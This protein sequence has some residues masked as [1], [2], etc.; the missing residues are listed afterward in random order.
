MPLSVRK[1]LREPLFHFLILGTAIFIVFQLVSKSVTS[2]PGKIFISQA[3]LAS[4]REGYA[5]TWHRLPTNDEMEGLVRERIKEEVYYQEALALG[6]DKE[7]I[8]IR[9]RLQQKM[10]FIAHDVARQPEPTDAAL[11]AFLEEHPDLFRSEARYSFH[12]IYLNTGRKGHIEIKEV[13]AL[14]SRLN[15]MDAKDDFHMWS[16][17]SLLPSDM[18]NAGATEIAGQ[19]GQEFTKQLR[20]LPAGS[21]AGPVNSAYGTHLVLLTERKNEGRPELA[22]IHDAVVREYDNARQL[23]ANE[24]FY[25]ELLKNYTVTIEKPALVKAGK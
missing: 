22:A 16:D 12:Q 11:S 10:E 23:A 15:R 3:E 18:Q 7:D 20:N 19:F 14:L 5:N 13:P 17:P 8:I 25:Q 21:W 4:I 6:L 9:R 24:K 1:I 2:E